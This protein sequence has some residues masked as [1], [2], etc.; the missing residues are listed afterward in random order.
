MHADAKVLTH[1]DPARS[2]RRERREVGG[3]HAEGGDHAAVIV[4]YGSRSMSTSGPPASPTS[5]VRPSRRGPSRAPN[6]SDRGPRRGPTPGAGRR[7]GEAGHGE[8][9]GMDLAIR[10]AEARPRREPPRPASNRIPH[11]LTDGVDRGGPVE[12]RGRVEV[13][14]EEHGH[15]V[16]G[17]PGS[18]SSCCWIAGR[19]VIRSSSTPRARGSPSRTQ[20]GPYGSDG[21]WTFRPRRTVPSPPRP[22]RRR[23]SRREGRRAGSAR[24]PAAAARVPAERVGDHALVGRPLLDADDVRVGRL[25]RRGR[26][27]RSS[28]GSPRRSRTTGPCRGS[29]H[30][31][32]RRCS[33]SSP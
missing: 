7:P 10:V 24:S 25:D 3:L 22:R 20:Y 8:R 18:T 5:S 17:K 6:R 30:R 32:R 4:G 26:P 21:R 13:A 1:E 9:I 16:V 15:A 31:R 11:L 14:G 12:V 27:A 29:T 2:H 19:R 28:R 23:R 33:A